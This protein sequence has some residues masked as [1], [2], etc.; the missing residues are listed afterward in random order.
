MAKKLRVLT[1]QTT[2][3]QTLAYDENDKVIYNETIVEITAKRDFES[4]NSKL[5]KQLQHKL[6]EFD[7][8]EKA[9]TDGKATGKGAAKDS[10]D[11]K[12]SKEEKAAT[13]GK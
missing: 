1:P 7:D 2:D 6:V 5:P 8:E 13:D 3:G 9:A 10:K 4:I 11:E 12:P